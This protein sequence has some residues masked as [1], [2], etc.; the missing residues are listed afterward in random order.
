MNADFLSL[1]RDCFCNFQFNV[2][3]CSIQGIFKTSD[4]VKN[5]PDSLACAADKVDVMIEQMIRFPIPAEELNRFRSDL[6]AIKPKRPY[7]FI[8]GHGLWNDLDLQATLDWL[9]TILETTLD[10]APW[11]SPSSAKNDGKVG[12]ERKGRKHERKR[13]T[14]FWPRLFMTPN[15]AGKE[16]PDQWIVS[17]GNKALMVFEE[18]V[19]VEVGRRGVE[20]LGMWNMSVQSNKFDGV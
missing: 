2:K 17:Q 6:P 10:A 11:L 13:E 16:K 18:S 15:A 5:D 19:K 1:S 8:F 14:G 9:D 4:V 3:E 12:K 7:A 20:H